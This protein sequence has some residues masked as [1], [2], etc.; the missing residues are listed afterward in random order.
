M[1]EEILAKIDAL[2]S[3]NRRLIAI[4]G[5]PASG[6]S[7]LA[8][9][10][11]EYYGEDAVALPMDGFHL[12]NRILAKKGLLDRKGAPE[13]FD[14]AGFIETVKRV[15]QGEHVYA[16]VFDREA[17]IAHA[18]AIEIFR[19]KIIVV[20]GNYLLV[21]Q[22]PWNKLSQY[23]DLAFWIELPMEAIEARCVARWLE[24]G[25][26][27]EAAEKRA[28]EN[29]LVNARF[30]VETALVQIPIIEL[31]AE[32]GKDSHG[33]DSEKYRKSI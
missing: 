27:R 26:S 9:Q 1:I 7:T 25:L 8:V 28:R 11:L 19:Q 12:D 17:D 2:P 14:S 29:D 5:A 33:F 20:E 31:I 3:K 22:E 10:L 6:K 21:G 30:V 18:G 32:K 4:A 13:T 24:H 23:W 15:A 16:P